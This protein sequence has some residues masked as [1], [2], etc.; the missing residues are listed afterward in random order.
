MRELR[1]RAT[2]TVAAPIAECFALLEAVDRYPAWYPEGFRDVEV[3][4]RGARGE[5]TEVRVKL[6]V[7]RGP[8]RRDFDL[9]M[10]VEADR[11]TSVK[12]TRLTNDPS[13]QQF[14]IGWRLR[15]MERTDIDL[16]LRAKL[17]VSRFLPLGG[18]GSSLADGFV[19]AASRAVLSRRR[20]S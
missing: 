9:V 1:G 5:P 10:A 6:H 4:A 11:P 8:L 12:L 20:G 3:L 7:S 18:V 19:V 15:G 17:R 16:D 14:E 2:Q 13:D